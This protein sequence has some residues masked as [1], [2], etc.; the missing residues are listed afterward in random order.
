MIYKNEKLL[1]SGNDGILKKYEIEYGDLENQIRLLPNDFIS[2]IIS[3]EN[4]EEI[5][6]C[7]FK[8][9]M[10]KSYFDCSEKI[11]FDLENKIGISKICFGQ[12]FNKLYA[13]FDDFK[14]REVDITEE[15]VE[16]DEFW[17]HSN[18]ILDLK[19]IEN[20][21]YISCDLDCNICVWDPRKGL[22]KDFKCESTPY[23]L[24]VEDEENVLIGCDNGDLLRFSI[25]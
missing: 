9:K 4:N 7:S 19:Q 20:F 25:N 3:K 5:F 8:G 11:I 24:F 12:N 21:L 1:T 22:V 14:I 10:G 23:C 6:F 15:I 16:E 2:C 18:K 13:V 17:E